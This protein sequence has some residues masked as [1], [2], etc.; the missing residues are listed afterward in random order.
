MQVSYMDTVVNP[1]RN[2]DILKKI[3]EEFTVFILS[4]IEQPRHNQFLAHQCRA[5]KRVLRIHSAWK[6]K[7]ILQGKW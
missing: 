3:F 1:A 5:I 2:I 4:K 6:F 7:I